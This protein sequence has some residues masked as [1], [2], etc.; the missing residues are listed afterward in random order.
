MTLTFPRDMPSVCRSMRSTIAPRYFQARNLTGGGSPDV[1]DLAPVVWEG[2][3]TVDL[4]SREDLGTW[5]AW[6]QSLRGG[7]R[8][9]KAVPPGRKWPLRYPRGFTGLTVSG[10][11]WDGTGN[12]SAIGVNRDT[13]TINQCPNGFT[14][15]PGDCFSLVHSSRSLLYRVTEGATGAAGTLTVSIEPTLRVGIT[16]GAELFFASP[17]CEMVLNARPSI[18]RLGKTGSVSFSGTQVL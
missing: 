16:T 5:E 14:L 17:Y 11:P 1:I 10:S 18:S 8:S 3:W 4:V 12:L 13:V 2:S 7:L 15:V 9:F 6:L